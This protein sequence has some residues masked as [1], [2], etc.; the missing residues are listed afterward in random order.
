MATATGSPPVRR[1]VNQRAL[2]PSFGVGALALRPGPWEQK[3]RHT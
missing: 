1:L 3:R 2:A